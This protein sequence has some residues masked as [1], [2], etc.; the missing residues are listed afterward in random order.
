[1]L[2]VCVCVVGANGCDKE[3][4]EVGREGKRRARICKRVWGDGPTFAG[5]WG[6]CGE[7]CVCVGGGR[8]RKGVR[9]SEKGR[10]GGGCK[11]K[12]SG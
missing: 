11:G 7:G 9:G 10:G 5:E 12:L 3:E 8:Q 2:C 1:M 6:L 4:G